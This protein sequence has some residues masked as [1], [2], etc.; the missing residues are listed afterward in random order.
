MNP[1]AEN[2]KPEATPSIP[3][4]RTFQGDVADALKNQ[5]ESVMSI[6]RAELTKQGGGNE[7]APRP[8]PQ[9][10]IEMRSS[11]KMILS[12]IGAIVLLALGGVLGWYAF[13]SYKV[14]TALPAVVV[15]P[16]QF[17]STDS[18]SNID[19]SGLARETFISAFNVLKSEN[20]KNNFVEQIQMKKGLGTTTVLLKTSEFFNILNTKAPASLVRALNP[21]FMLGTIGEINGASSTPHTFLLFKLD[22]FENVFAGMLGWEPSLGE[23]LLPLFVSEETA[24]NFPTQN[25]FVDVT[26]QNKDAR[27]LKDSN[28]NTVMLYS[29]FDNN[30]LIIADNS[31]TLRALVIKLNTSKLSR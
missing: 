13:N 2:P 8:T 27:A 12:I 5:G 18:T 29:F 26:I 28:G 7:F 31:T 6:R 15:T 17:I 14:K 19:A 25:Q 20:L 16:N 21:N 22:S 30:T 10:Q 3:Q 4:I 23:D 11:Q 1:E 24:A 9:E